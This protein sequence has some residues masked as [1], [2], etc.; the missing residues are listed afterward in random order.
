MGIFY[1]NDGYFVTD[2]LDI[3][4]LTY[5]TPKGIKAKEACKKIE[6]WYLETKCRQT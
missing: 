6:K 2:T 5:L 4:P 1:S 3:Q